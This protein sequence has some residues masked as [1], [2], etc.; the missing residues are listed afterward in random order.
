M[1]DTIIISGASVILLKLKISSANWFGSE[2]PP[3]PIRMKPKVKKLMNSTKL[4][5][6]FFV[7]I[8]RFCF[9]T[10]KNKKVQINHKKKPVPK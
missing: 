3:P 6:F 9:S 5:Y 2:D 10:L 8:M 1:Y 7:K 4:K